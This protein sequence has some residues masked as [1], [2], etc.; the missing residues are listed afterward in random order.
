[1]PNLD[2]PYQRAR[3]LSQELGQPGVRALQLAAKKAGIPVTKAEVEQIV[4]QQGERQVFGRLQGAEG[5]TVSRGAND[6]WQMDLA[7]LKNQPGTK[8]KK[9]QDRIYKFF[10][11]VI[12]TFDRVVYTR[13]LKGKE[14][15]EVKTKLNQILE[16]APKKPKVISSDNGNE[17][18]GEVS[19]YLQGRGSRRGSRP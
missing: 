2:T 6:S 4:K 11:V 13:A 10:L 3:K 7:D 9:K 18:L 17:F 15:W 1:M 5:K 8:A 16:E 19:E 14:P 12:N